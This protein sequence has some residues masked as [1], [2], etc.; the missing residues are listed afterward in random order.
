MEI[1]YKKLSKDSV[2]PIYSK[3]HDCGL[4]LTAVSVDYSKANSIDG[5]VEYDTQIALSVPVGY[6][7]FL[8]AR[9][10][11]TNKPMMLKNGVGILD[12]GY[13]GAIKARFVAIEKNIEKNYKV[14]DRIIQLVIVPCIKAELVE[15][16]ELEQTERGEG[17]FGSTN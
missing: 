2:T 17:G 3:E 11:V 14:G 1:K 4:D 16:E 8:T 9:S 6:C 10:S 12:P 7:G 15:V 5:Y 13:V